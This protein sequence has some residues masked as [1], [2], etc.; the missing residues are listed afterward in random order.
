MPAGHT[1][2]LHLMR[3]MA[4]ARPRLGYA[5]FHEYCSPILSSLLSP[6]RYIEGL[7]FFFISQAIPSGLLTSRIFGLLLLI[8]IFHYWGLFWLV[9]TSHTRRLMLFRDRYA[10]RVRLFFFLLRF[11][12]T[13]RYYMITISSRSF[14]PHHYYQ[15][16][17]PILLEVSYANENKLLFRLSIIQ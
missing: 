13:I 6:I 2:F 11:S 12:F 4:T 8:Y 7:C 1:R 17:I 10:S 5:G 9:N 14:S 15:S 16:I 3:A